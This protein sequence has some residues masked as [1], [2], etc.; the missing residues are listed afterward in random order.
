MPPKR[1]APGDW[2]LPL[3]C[4]SFGGSWFSLANKIPQGACQFDHKAAY[5]SD[6]MD[7]CL[8]L[9]MNAGLEWRSSAQEMGKKYPAEISTC[10]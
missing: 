2:R 3:L 10:A 1:S 9:S 6:I 8:L 4:S 5:I 7:I